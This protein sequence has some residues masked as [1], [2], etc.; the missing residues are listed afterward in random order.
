[1]SA[2][3]PTPPASRSGFAAPF[4]R[5]LVLIGS[6]MLLGALW[7]GWGYDRTV[8]PARS[9]NAWAL[10]ERTDWLLAL[11][12]LVTLIG[13][14]WPNRRVGLSLSGIGVLG[15]IALVVKL[16]IQTDPARGPRYTLLA[17]AV[18]IAGI[19][20]EL[21]PASVKARAAPLGAMGMRGFAWV[22]R[23]QPSGN[24]WRSFGRL[25]WGLVTST[26]VLALLVWLIAAPLIPLSPGGGTDGSW[27]TALH[28]AHERG[29]DFG[30][31]IMYTYGPLGYLT[32]PRAY[33]PAGLRE[34]WVYYQLVY[35]GLAFAVIAAGRRSF[36]ALV[37]AVIAILTLECFRIISPDEQSQFAV[38]TI[39]FIAAAALIRAPELRE[40][41]WWLPAIGVAGAI[42]GLES[43]MKL[44]SGLT[45]VLVLGLASLAAGPWRR[46]W[47][48]AV[49]AG[50]YVVG[51][52]AGWWWAGQALGSLYDYFR[53]S[54]EIITGY[55]EYSYAED[56]TR[57]W[58]YLAA[59][60]LIAT[61]LCVAWRES[62]GFKRRARAAWLLITALTL[63]STFKQG[64]V[65]HDAHSL[66]FFATALGVAIG[67][68]WMKR[69]R[70]PG[71]LVVGACVLMYL[72]VAKP[73]LYEFH[74]P[75][76]TITA[77]RESL[78]T[79]RHPEALNTL[80]RQQT[81]AKQNIPP[82]A[83]RLIGDRPVH[84]F[85]TETSVA[86]SQPQLNWRPLPVIQGFLA[87]TPYLDGLNADLLRSD[88]APERILRTKEHSAFEDPEAVMEVACRY[89]EL[90]AQGDWQVLG[91]VPNRCGPARM[92]QRVATSTEQP[93][94][95][96]SVGPDEL[97]YFRV[98]KGW[99]P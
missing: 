26:P 1:M 35:Y 53:G 77:V 47:G 11:L 74:R 59:A 98:V 99:Q 44:N 91:R 73:L 81:A 32:V 24:D 5:A 67:L 57:G 87:Y 50:G 9:L 19:A 94:D 65:R 60:G 93:I 25:V 55:P 82:E 54:F 92:V 71:Y 70:L 16:L 63:Y 7:G 72:A 29:L 43:L 45:L 85:P 84:F 61:L 49:F 20:V 83:L 15:S 34:G 12:A 18:V 33:D 51:L 27:I 76:G 36:P 46:P 40:R 89:V 97:L 95:V 8:V 48:A 4:A 37:A 78:D 23:Q 96:P 79:L 58:E 39:G 6:V 86:W 88:R 13:A 30:R 64:F 56:S 21:A 80:A 38:L 42:A 66:Q 41:R 52:L 22:T 10:L 75:R 14:L 28:L 69:P 62:D 2:T 31:D 17:A 3:A 90:F 68:G